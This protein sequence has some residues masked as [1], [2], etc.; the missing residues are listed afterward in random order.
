MRDFV[1]R[2]GRKPEGL[3][4]PETAVDTPTLEALAEQGIAFTIL[5]PHQAKRIRQIGQTAWRSVTAEQLG[6]ARPYLCRLPSGKSIVLFFYHGGLARGVAFEGLLNSGDRFVEQLQKAFSAETP[7]PQLVHLATDGE[8]YGHHHRFGEMALAFAAH[9]LEQGKSVQLTNYGEFLALHPPGWEVEIAENTSWSCAHGIERWRADCGCRIGGQRAWAQ[10]WRAP[11][12][13]AL[14]W[15]SGEIDSFFERRSERLLIDPWAARDAYIEVLLDHA[16]ERVDEF[17]GRHARKWLAPAQKVE[18]RKL[19]EMQRHRLLM[20]TSCGWFFDEISGIEGVQILQYAARAAEIAGEL[21][22]PLEAG[23]VE[24]LRQA[25][26]NITEIRDGGRVYIEKVKPNRVDFPRMTAN[27]A[28]CRVL[29][30]SLSC[31][32]PAAST[33]KLTDYTTDTYGATALGVGRMHLT[34]PATGESNEYAFAVLKLT[35]HDVH[36]V[37]SE[38]LVGEQFTAIRDELLSTFARHSLSEVVR[39]LDRAFGETYYTAK[40]LLLDDRR[41]VLAGVSDTVLTRLE[42]SYR[43]LYQENRRL[44]EYLRELDVPLPQGFS[45]AAGFLASRALARAAAALLHNAEDGAGLIAIVEEARLWRVPLETKGVEDMLRLAVEERCAALRTD[46]FAAEI[47]S[48][49]HLLELAERLGLTINLWKTQT[50]FAQACQQHLQELL[51]RR[52]HEEPVAHQVVL[53]RRLGERLGFYA[54]EDMPLETWDK[55]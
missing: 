31:A 45:L 43:Q 40:D 9:T 21:G 4:L 5:A 35:S 48:I 54:V 10:K 15:L 53:L 51:A 32:V 18:A 38:T 30:H 13:A 49:L 37:V 41:R 47:P 26:S 3:W 27:Y 50:L 39:V 36:C 24:R 34:S 7:E 29:E 55:N 16:P 28:I 12:R 44:M 1:H 8:S 19:L 20:F 52:E 2:F 25:P 14:E 23:F 42:E 6:T 17:C 46:P 33:L 11:L 22:L